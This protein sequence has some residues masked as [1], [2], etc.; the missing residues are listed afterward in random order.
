MNISALKSPGFRLYLLG[1]FISLHGLWI[2][3][4]V[5]GWLAWELTNSPG[6]VGF[7]AFLTLAPTLISGPLFG[8]I[9]DRMNIRLAFFLSYSA[10]IVCSFLLFLSLS[11]SL[12]NPNILAVFCLFIGVIASASHPIRMSLAPRLVNNSQLPSVVALTAVNFNT[13]RLIGPAIGGTL[14]QLI[15]VNSTILFAVFAYLPTMVFITIIKPRELKIENNKNNTILYSFFEGTKLILSSNIIKFSIVLSGVTAFIGR[16]VLETLPLISEGIFSKGPSGLGLITAVAGA[17][18]LVSSIF[19]TLGSK[20]VAGLGIS[21]GNL[22][23]ALSIPI[24]VLIIGFADSFNTVLFLV[25]ILGFLATSLGISIQSKIQLELSDKFRGR[26]MSIWT[27]VSM[28][29]AAL[30]AMIFGI[31]SD[32]TNI[33]FTQILF[34]ITFIIFVFILISINKIRL[35]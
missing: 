32:F 30:G 31:V 7:T 1:S 5:L 26:V 15:G 14:I 2:Q 24:A 35:N 8:V 17:G 4:V 27:M 19:K 22:I 3:R 21:K 20:E 13:S 11:F 10:M 12:L 34:G 33:Q 9:I 18:A 29:S 6:F 16:G 23:L 28:G 25:F